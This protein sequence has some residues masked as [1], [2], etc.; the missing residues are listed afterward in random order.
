MA[1][2]VLTA[3]GTL[4]G[5]PIGGALGA[6]AGQAID[7][8]IFR[9]AGRSGPRLND[10]QVQT[11]RYGTR[12]PRIF[13]QLRVAGT[14]IWATDLKE[15]SATS[16]GGKGRPSVTS[17]SYTASLAVALSA[18]RIT[19]IRRIW[20]DGNLLRGAAG[21]FKA[22]VGAFR[23]HS[24]DEDQ[25]VD[26]LIAADVGLDRAPAFR[27]CAY[28]VFE[29]LQLADFG[30]RIPSLTFE[31]IADGGAAGMAA[32]AS[33]LAGEAI[34]Y[35][36]DAPGASFF[37]FA[38]DGA[39]LRDAM[40]ALVEMNDLLWREE[41]SA[42]ILAGGQE[43]DYRIDPAAEVCAIDGKA[44]A[45][46]S[47][48][49]LPIETVPA[50]LSIRYHD[51]ER[52]F[53]AGIQ[54]AERPGPGARQDNVDLPAALSAAA[55]RRLADA[56][57]RSG[58]RRRT[59]IRRSIGWAALECEIGD[60][61]TLTDE[62]GRWRVE[63]VAWENM[64]VRLTLRAHD[65]GARAVAGGGDAGTSLRETDLVQGATHLAIVELPPDG[66]TLA[67]V[68]TVYAAATGADAGWRRAVLL[69]YHAALET[70]EPIGRT[71]LR[72]VIGTTQGA[73]PDGVPW[74]IDRRGAVEI[75]LDNA[76]DALTAATDDQL[77]AGA[78]LCG[79]GDEVLQFGEAEPIGPGR[80]RL[81]RLIRG[82]HGTEWA[83]AGHQ[84][85]ERFVLLDSDRLAPVNMTPADIG[86]QLALRAIGSGDLVPAE[87]SGLIDGR[88]SVPPA[89]VHGR[90]KGAGQGGLVISWVRRSRLGWAWPDLGEIALGEESERYLLRVG[91]AATVL[92]AWETSD[93]SS[94]YPAADIAADRAAAAG[95]P[96]R[97]EIMQRGTS[98]LSRPLVLPLP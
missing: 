24:G 57:L 21:D 33:E 46:E 71:A 7:A 96:L 28:A 13:G 93:S 90:I 36:G 18:R 39:D 50:R 82:W 29:G 17:Y 5:G 34:A 1:T 84:P 56:K 41:G 60:V 30:N 63:A 70:A 54:T 73:L 98:G 23:F 31:V 3:V 16:G 86:Q 81:S 95:A 49:R 20:A 69:R 48:Q 53:Q 14:V 79:I 47:R 91:T 52:D 35:R 68:P 40:G 4:F 77:L 2:I 45:P 11:S 61:V 67:T 42:L 43:R 83:C 92:R 22:P 55:A 38:A 37:G 97:L 27:G 94:S 44:E 25:A 65:G 75:W 58:L 89:P 10:L 78:N 12:V 59:L 15:S 74:R 72:A 85:D 80:F 6:L 64:A 9:P 76:A 66:L 51:P 8:Q 32:I 19:G 88:A 87:A 62:P 26:P